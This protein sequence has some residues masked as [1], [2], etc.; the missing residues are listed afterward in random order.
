MIH[1]IVQQGATWSPVGT[2][3]RSLLRITE[4]WNMLEEATTHPCFADQTIQCCPPDMPIGKSPRNRCFRISGWINLMFLHFPELSSIPE[5]C[6]S[7]L[8]PSLQ[9]PLDKACPK[10]IRVTRWFRWFLSC[11]K[12]KKHQWTQDSSMS[13]FCWFQSHYVSETHHCLKQASCCMLVASA[14]VWQCHGA[15]QSDGSQ[16]WSKWHFGIMI[17]ETNL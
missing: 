12:N 4:S 5:G 1:Y 17:F 8:L 15:F 7:W 16:Q 14:G 3:C 13:M 9:S 2:Q 6:F 11:L 10:K